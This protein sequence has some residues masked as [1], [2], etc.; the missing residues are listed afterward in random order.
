MRQQMALI[1]H[2]LVRFGKWK[3]AVRYGFGKNS[4][5]YHNQFPTG[6]LFKCGRYGIALF[7]I[8]RTFP[9]FRPFSALIRTFSG[10]PHLLAQLT[11][12]RTI[13][14]NLGYKNQLK[15]WKVLVPWVG[16]FWYCELESIGTDL[17]SFGTVIYDLE[18]VGSRSWKVLEPMWKVLVPRYVIWKVLVLG[19]GKYWNRSGKFWYSDIWLEKFWYCELECNGTDLESFGTRSWKVLE[20]IWKVLVP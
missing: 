19:V 1:R 14:H 18:S 3:A 17:E 9:H 8:L 2:G 10:F 20:P 5:Y 4:Q 6:A 16:K 12:F 7:D 15:S 11:S 13:L